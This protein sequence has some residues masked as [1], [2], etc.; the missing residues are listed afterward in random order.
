M[1]LNTKIITINMQELVHEN[2][3]GVYPNTLMVFEWLCNRTNMRANRVFVSALV[4]MTE[5]E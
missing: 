1:T 2:Y 4:E 5:K 3:F